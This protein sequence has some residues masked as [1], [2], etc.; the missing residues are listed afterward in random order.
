MNKVLRYS[1][2]VL[3][4][5][6]FLFS[7]AYTLQKKVSKDKTPPTVILSIPA[8]TGKNGWYNEPIP[9]RVIA[10]DG[11]SGVGSIQVSL[12]GGTWYRNAL[13]IR[14][15]GTYLVIGKASDHSGNSA[16]VSQVVHLD[17]TA[18]TV[19][20]VV[21]EA[22]GTSDWHLDSVNISL[23]G[24]DELSGVYQTD[25][26]A[27]GNYD[28]AERDL[29]DLQEVY[30]PVDSQANSQYIV[31]G[32]IIS[33]TE[34]DIE[35]TQS[36]NYQISGYVE[37]VAGNRTP[38][39]TQI[40]IDINDPQITF[41]PPETYFGEIELGGSISDHES[42]VKK[43]WVDKGDGWQV[44]DF[45]QSSWL[46]PWQTD[47][48]QDDKY[49]IRAKVMDKAGNSTETSYTVTVV[50]NI[51]PILAICG[52]L[53]S[54]GLVTLYDPRRRAFRKLTLTLAKYSHMDHSASQIRK[55]WYD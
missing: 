14:R 53:L 55:D 40:S 2:L 4:A 35:L 50:N 52:V 36:G 23:S 45:N 5:A 41:N 24:S 27:K 44:A 51:W 37:D 39:E 21:P 32:N 33:E 22:Q 26:I 29:I 18:P 20:F 28:Q 19:D 46:V 1:L 15:D 47:D 3:S 9:V 54:L 8:P 17:M 38:V 12:G 13:T 30:L 43:V 34:A 49:V 11:G 7:P 10:W 48:L 6:L 42:G 31:L 16:K 25:L